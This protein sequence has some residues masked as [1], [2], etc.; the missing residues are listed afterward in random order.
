MRRPVGRRAD[1]IKKI[2]ETT[3]WVALKAGLSSLPAQAAASAARRRCCSPRKARDSSQS[4]ASEG[5]GH[6]TSNRFAKPAAPR[7]LVLADAGSEQD[8]QAFIAKAISAY[9]KLDGIRANAGISGGLV[10]SPNRPGALAGN[11]A[12][13]P[14]RAVPGGETFHSDMVKQGHGA[15]VCAASVAGLE[16]YGASAI[17]MPPARPA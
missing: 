14:D 8:V 13:Q 5:Q 15:I 6:P 10:P 2:Q 16:V 3:S 7:K 4:I 12:R 17:P 1:L 9:G 11:P